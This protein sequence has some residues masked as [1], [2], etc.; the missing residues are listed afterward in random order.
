MKIAITG[1]TKGIGKALYTTLS[2]RGHEV[3]GYSRSNG[4]DI[5][6]PTVRNLILTEIKTF[7]VFINNAYSATAQ[8]TLLKESIDSWDG[9]KKIIINVGSKSIYADTF[10]NFMKP[11]IEDKK[12]QDELLRQRKLKARPHTLNLILGLV[13]TQMS[14]M[15]AADKLAPEHVAELLANLL[16]LKDQIYV[17]EL[18]I[19]VPFQDW[20]NIRTKTL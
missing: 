9:E 15:L 10:P 6:D 4:Y 17:Q 5:S 1:H 18:M 2:K 11:Y 14:D 12:K 13:N 3:Y 19:D 20:D 7:D 8:Y 16:E